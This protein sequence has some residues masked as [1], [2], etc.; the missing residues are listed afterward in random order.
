MQLLVFFLFLFVHCLCFS[1]VCSLLRCTITDYNNTACKTKK[2]T[3][4]EC[5]E[6]ILDPLGHHAASY[7]RSGDVVAWHNHM[8][9]I[10]VVVPIFQ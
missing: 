5:S 9:D 10:F 4:S 8:R 3:G 7:R 2:K 1:V 6:I